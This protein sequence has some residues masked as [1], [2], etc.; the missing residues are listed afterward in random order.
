MDLFEYRNEELS[1]EQ[2]P[3]ASRMRPRNLEEFVGQEKVVGEGTYLRK[4]IGEDRLQTAIF[5][6]PPGSGK[7]TLASIIANLTRAHFRRLS[8]VTSGV[9]E[10]RALIKEAEDRLA[11]EG[12]RTILFIDEIHRFNKAQ[13]DALLPAVEKGTIVLIGATTENPYFEVNSALVSRSKVFRLDPLS[14]DEVRTVVERALADE[15]R[16]LGGLGLEIEEEALE[17]IVRMAG[18]DARIALNTLEAA[19]LLAAEEG[20]RRRV[21]LA[22]AEEAAQR[23]A[24]LYDK[25]GDAHYDTVSAFIK[26][27]RGSDPQ[28]A[29]YWLARMLKAGEDPRFIARRMVIFAS[30]DVGLADSG[31]LVVADA[32]ARAVEFVGMPECALNLAHAA[33]Y[34]ALAPKSNSATRAISAASREVERGVTQGV[35]LHLRDSHYRGAA[36]LGHGKGYLY[37]HDYPGHHVRQDYL[38]EGIK[39]AI[40][41]EPACEG[42]ERHLV[43]AWRKRV[44][45]GEGAVEGHEVERSGDVPEGPAPEEGEDEGAGPAKPRG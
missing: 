37:P 30:E 16:G 24:L 22:T 43:E 27:M 12:A 7:T 38:P 23:K 11:M 32:A 19:A 17:H 25:W 21:D 20:G 13:Q 15:E 28:A 35:P 31:A 4:A 9:A 26:S 36:E 34:L 10:V 29:V 45:E 5:W 1:K 3:L 42:E 40:Y 33:L 8:A 18:G 2:A 39:G 41:Y 6:G 44:M 14:E